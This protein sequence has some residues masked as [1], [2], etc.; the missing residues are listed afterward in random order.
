[1]QCGKYDM[2]P[3]AHWNTREDLESGNWPVYGQFL[4][5]VSS[6]AACSAD[7]FPGL[8]NDQYGFFNVASKAGKI[9]FHF[10]LMLIHLP[11]DKETHLWPD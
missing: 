3:L 11:M 4:W 5:T 10:I 6:S 7:S 8:G 1:M 2:Q 9:G